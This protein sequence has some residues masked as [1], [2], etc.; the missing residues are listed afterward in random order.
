INMSFGSVTSSAILSNAVNYAINRGVPMVAAVGNQ[1]NSSVFYPAAYPNVI[2]VSGV[3]RN[4]N[5]PSFANYGNNI[6]LVAPATDII[7]AGL[8]NGPS[9]EYVQGSGTSFAA[10]QVTGAASLILGRY[11]GTAPGILESVLKTSSDTL[12]ENNPQYF[13]SGVLNILKAI[14]SSPITTSNVSIVNG[15][16][17]ADGVSM[18]RVTVVLQDADGRVKANQEIL[19][20]A[21]GSNTIINGQVVPVTSS[22]SLGRTDNLGRVNFEVSSTTVGYKE[23]TFIDN[24]TQTSLRGR[25]PLTFTAPARPNYSMQ[26]VKQSAYP[27]LVV[28]ESAELW[29]EVKNTGNIAWISDPQAGLD[30]KG[31]IKLGTDRP[32]DRLSVFKS[33]S[34]ISSNRASYMSPPVV[35]PGESARFTFKI[36]ASGTGTFREYFRPVVEYVSWLNDLGIYW[37]IKVSPING[38]ISLVNLDSIDT[39]PEHYQAVV[40]SQSSDVTMGPGDTTQLFITFT[41]IGSTVW[42]GQGAGNNRFGEVRIGTVQERDRSSPFSYLS[43]ISPN[44]VINAGLDIVPGKRLTLTFTIKAPD[45]PGVYQENFQLV[46]EYITWFGPVFGWTITVI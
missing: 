29:V 12:R 20:R 36:L 5:Y 32:T 30:G 34:W 8:V 4:D 40:T 28:G 43:W 11:P 31:Q 13:G 27:T 24:T 41:N 2:A 22:L 25:A 1:S 33:S 19:V 45:R 42:Y 14:G 44:R 37:N 23:L 21:T 9:G 15:V 18:A 17:P 7:M 10:A 46:S 3:D 39:N 38:E 26:W 16:L 6:D 35:R